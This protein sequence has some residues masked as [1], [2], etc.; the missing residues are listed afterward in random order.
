MTTGQ[1]PH[2]TGG[3]D[4]VHMRTVQVGGASLSVIEAG[5]GQTVVLMHGIPT[6]AELFRDVVARLAD[7]G[8]HAVAP[9]LPGYGATR[10]ASGADYSMSGAAELLAE[11]LTQEKL[12]PVW[13]VGHDA[14]GAVAQ[15]LV[16]RSQDLVSHLTLINS[17]VDGSWP[18]P[19]A[20]AARLAARLGLVSAAGKL[21]LAPNPV[22]RWFIR[23][24]FSDPAGADTATVNGVVFDGKFTDPAGRRE[25]QRSLAALTWSDTALVAQRL[26]E[27]TIPCQLIWAMS[28]PF[29][30]WKVGGRRLAALMPQASITRLDDC[31]HFAPLECPQRLV[32][33]MLV[34][35]HAPPG[36]TVQVGPRG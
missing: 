35:R 33:T 31:G 7:A 21:K 23:R 6:S 5:A 25:F 30:T 12:A 19:R 27:L 14:G 10:L 18:A 28:D 15:I 4:P 29:Q 9:A 11:W 1:S 8:F 2:D 36:S 34:W 32:D 3:M 16:L 24:A 22:I 13:L 26:C 17:L 20:R